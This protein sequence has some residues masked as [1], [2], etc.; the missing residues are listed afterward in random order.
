M[1]HRRESLLSLIAGNLY[2]DPIWIEKLARF[3]EIRHQKHKKYT[4][5]ARFREPLSFP[6]VS[7]S[8]SS[9]PVFSSPMKRRRRRITRGRERQRG[10]G[11][12]RERER[13]EERQTT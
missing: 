9:F 11:R 5:L 3:R 12:E 8:S 13:G 6:S 2:S 4:R 10:R 1:T 7:S